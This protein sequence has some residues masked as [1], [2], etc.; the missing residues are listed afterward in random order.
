MTINLHIYDMQHQKILVNPISAEV[1]TKMSHY[2]YLV[3]YFSA[4]FSASL[5][6]WIEHAS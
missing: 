1:K 5:D 4:F 3:S 6:W 2:L